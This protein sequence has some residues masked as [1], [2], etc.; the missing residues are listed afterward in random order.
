M[1]HFF[2]YIMPRGMAGELST[3]SCVLVADPHHDSV[4]GPDCN[5]NT[6]QRSAGVRCARD[7]CRDCPEETV[8][9]FI[10]RFFSWIPGH[11][12]YDSQIRVL[13]VDN[14]KR[15]SGLSLTEKER[16]FIGLGSCFFLNF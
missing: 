15:H 14:E 13:L 11:G 5:T 8:I 4:T 10:S 12:V 7:R 2:R 1:I 9:F 6:A 16:L 3:C